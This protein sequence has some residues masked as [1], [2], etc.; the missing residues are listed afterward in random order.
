MSLTSALGT[1]QNA[2]LNTSRQTSV[3][4]SNISNAHDPNYS[5]RIAQTI[6][7]APGARILNVK[8]LADDSLFRQNLTALS[9]FNGQ[10][11]LMAGLDRMSMSVN[12][13]DNATS[14]A[15]MIGKLQEAMQLYSSNPSNRNLAESAVE[16]ARAVVNSLN[17]G[18][19][20]I[21]AMRADMDRQ[22]NTAVEEL[23]T[24]LSQFEKVNAE[25]INGT[26]MGRDISDVLDQRDALLKDISEYVSIS[27]IVRGQNDLVITTSD[28]ATLFETIPRKVSFDPM[29][30][31]QAGMS[32]EAIRI[33]GVPVVAGKGANTT[34]N[35][36]LAAM[37]QLREDVAVKQQAQLDEMAR[38][39]ILAFAEDET[40]EIAG[41]FTAAGPFPEDTLIN[42]L[43][44]AIRINPEYDSQQGGDPEALRDG[45]TGALNPTGAASFSETLLSY[46]DRME[47]DRPF[48]PEAGLFASGSLANFSTESIGW[49]EGNR[50]AASF[51]MENKGATMMRT[52]QALSNQ[53]GVNI[54]QE[55]A[56]LLDLEHS[57]AAS[58]RMLQAVNEMLATLLNSVR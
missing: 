40:G 21:Q 46:L 29:L 6:S 54:D 33:D 39:L 41:L 44:A 4:A 42:G 12:G 52:E 53:T 5:R 9:A 34:A 16:S 23:N 55:M 8:R 17:N 48:D 19:K 51:A 3:V 50:K 58:A 26:R 25:V 56:M 28:G 49:L 36:K 32:G 15:T 45:A 20:E 37:I 7:M 11:I 2:L 35:G 57:Y 47:A 13:P 43:A 30:A 31:Y 27:T 1:A 24:L 18:S 38:G 14:P 22:I 10:N